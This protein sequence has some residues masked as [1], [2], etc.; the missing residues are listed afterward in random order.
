MK[1]SL[2]VFMVFLLHAE[3]EYSV[4]WNDTEHIG[5]YDQMIQYQSIS[6]SS[7]SL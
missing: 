3:E 1:I 2:Q 6:L 5:K 4:C 7:I